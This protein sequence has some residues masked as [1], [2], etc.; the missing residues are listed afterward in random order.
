MAD[1]VLESRVWLGR[2]RPEVFAFFADPQNL[3]RVV[4]PWLGFRVVSA[5]PTLAAGA[6]LDLSVRWLGGRLAWR[7]YIR[8]FDPP[9]RFVDVQVRGPYARWEHRHRFLDDEGATMVEDRVT[10][11]L[12]VGPLG[13]LA[14]AL[15][16]GRQLRALWAYRK[17]KLDALLGPVLRHDA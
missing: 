3:A 11:R 6:V 17:R 9:F 16:V 5:P 14:H 13:R 7:S 12:P 1:F 2:P 10:Y 15:I 8:E 4:P